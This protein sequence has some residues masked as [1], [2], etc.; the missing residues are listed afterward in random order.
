MFEGGC[1]CGAVRYACA[2]EPAMSG[3]CHCIDCRRSSGSGHSS[4][5]AVPKETVTLS[6]RLSE[7]AAPADSGNMVTRAFC[8]TC[9]APVFSTN[10]AM[11]ELIFLRASSLDD[12]EV[13]QPQM[14]V[15]A[16]RA[17]SWDRM[18]AGLPTFPRMPPAPPSS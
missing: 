2:G 15:F 5:M 6:G 13:F 10:T 18:D 17:P 7:Y 4:H 16:S 9:G 1:L 12:L 8:P 11:P 14:V 3:H